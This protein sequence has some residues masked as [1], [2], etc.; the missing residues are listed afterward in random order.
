MDVLEQGKLRGVL[1]FIPCPGC[2]NRLE[3][4]GHPVLQLSPSRQFLAV[5]PGTCGNF[6]LK[7]FWFQFPVAGLRECFLHC[8]QWQK[9]SEDVH[10]SMGKTLDGLIVSGLFESMS[11]VAVPS[12]PASLEEALEGERSHGDPQSQC[13]HCLPAG[14]CS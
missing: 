13:P 12:L 6:P 3:R 9:A 1:G 7:P 4:L 11:L 8:L 5:C 10:G 2:R 14:P